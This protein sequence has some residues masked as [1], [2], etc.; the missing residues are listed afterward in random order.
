VTVVVWLAGNLQVQ[1][2]KPDYSLAA[3]PCISCNFQL[4]RTLVNLTFFISVSTVNLVTRRVFETLN[5]VGLLTPSNVATNLQVTNAASA[6]FL[7]S[8]CSL[9]L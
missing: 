4:G 3:T 8:L 6:H 5:T 9:F 2:S 1:L 7:P